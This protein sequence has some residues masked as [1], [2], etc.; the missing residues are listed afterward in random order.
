MQRGSSACVHSLAGRPELNG[1]MVTLTS[2]DEST[3]RWIC[4]T[5]DGG[6]VALR[7]TNLQAVR[8][9]GARAAGAPTRFDLSALPWKHF[10]IGL[11]VTLAVGHIALTLL[12]SHTLPN[13]A[14]T[15]SSARP[16]RASSAPAGYGV[17]IVSWL[18]LAGLG[19]LSFFVWALFVDSGG[20]PLGTPLQRQVRGGF[21]R[22]VSAAS[23][24]D[25]FLVL[26]LVLGVMLS[27][28]IYT[29]Q[30]RLDLDASRLI[31]LPVIAYVFWRSRD[32]LHN[33]NPFQ[34]LMLID[35]LQRL[36]RPGGGGGG[37]YPYRG[38]Y[39]RTRLFF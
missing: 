26:V 3:A 18:P 10:V 8:N 2:F 37:G 4:R 20:G 7:A 36:F 31:M 11:C 14:P 23:E 39:R 6:R 32:N 5:T 35:M 12:N 1:E 38:G 21:A 19:A 34:L 30:L 27:W 28:S 13:A 9:H 17:E 25:S 16:A 29:D 15:R 24:L 33:M 22:A